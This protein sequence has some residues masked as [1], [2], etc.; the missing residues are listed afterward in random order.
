MAAQGLPLCLVWALPP[1]IVPA[2][3]MDDAS[4]RIG[5]AVGRPVDRARRRTA[6]TDPH[7]RDEGSRR[8]SS[9]VPDGGARQ[10]PR[11]PATDAAVAGLYGHRGAR[12]IGIRL[13]SARVRTPLG[14]D[15]HRAAL[16]GAAGTRGR[17]QSSSGRKMCG[18]AHALQIGVAASRS[19]RGI[20]TFRSGYRHS[21][22]YTRSAPYLDVDQPSKRAAL[23][24]VRRQVERLGLLR[25]HRER[26][27]HDRVGT[28]E[29]SEDRTIRSTVAAQP[30]IAPPA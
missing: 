1:T 30:S 28:L 23:D 16:T 6:S 9:K 11:F 5:E 12:R 3:A 21:T 10:T 15:V 24:P 27:R 22:S 25:D 2:C 19:P 20:G 7:A 8:T 13:G 18:A 29:S 17:G 14:R 4:N 26:Q